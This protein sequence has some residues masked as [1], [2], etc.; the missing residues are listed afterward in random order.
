MSKK[1]LL[2]LA[3]AALRRAEALKKQGL[4]NAAAFALQLANINLQHAK[5][6]TV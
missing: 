5:R 4:H 3:L 1:K 2:N 6:A